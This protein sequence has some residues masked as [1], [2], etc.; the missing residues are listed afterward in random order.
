M[1]G[2]KRNGGFWDFAPVGWWWAGARIM[3]AAGVTGTDALPGGLR[4]TFAADSVLEF[5]L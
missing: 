2:A 3:A 1:P 4:Y 5:K